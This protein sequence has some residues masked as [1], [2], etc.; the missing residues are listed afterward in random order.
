MRRFR[1]LLKVA[2]YLTL[3]WLLWFDRGSILAQ[4]SVTCDQKPGRAVTMFEGEVC[5]GSRFERAFGE[6]FVFNLLPYEKGWLIRIT[7]LGEEDDNLSRLTPPLHGANPTDIQGWHFRNESNTGPNTGS[8]N[9]PGKR[10]R[11]IFSPEVDLLSPLGQVPTAESV[12]RVEDFGV[13]ELEVLDFGLADLEPGKQAR[14]V[15]L[16]FRVCLAWR[17]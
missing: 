1:T 6:N 9:V 11:F 16:K 13:G 4:A 14:M 8:L 7:R 3:V 2:S 12:K 5:S 15:W 17:K 10:R